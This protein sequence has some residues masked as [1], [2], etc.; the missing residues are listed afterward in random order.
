MFKTIEGQARY[1]AAYDAT[2]ALWLVLASPERVRKLVLMAPASLSPLRKR[3]FFRM[4]SAV[5]MAAVLA[6]EYIQKLF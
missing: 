3:F 5:L 6:P 1:F 4:M 2:L